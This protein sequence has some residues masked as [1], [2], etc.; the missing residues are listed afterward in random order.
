MP[1]GDEADLP[2][3]DPHEAGF[4]SGGAIP[5]AQEAVDEMGMSRR[6]ESRRG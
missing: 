5:E 2:G 1:F 3:L 4:A 6:F